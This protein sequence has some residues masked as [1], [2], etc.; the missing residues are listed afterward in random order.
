M[1]T[2]LLE[3]RPTQLL[4]MNLVEQL[5][6]LMQGVKG[7]KHVDTRLIITGQ[8]PV[9]P[10]VQIALYR[11]AQEALNNIVKHTHAT[12]IEIAYSSLPERVELSIWDNGSGFDPKQAKGGAGVEAMRERAASIQASLEIASSQQNGTRVSVRWVPEN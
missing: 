11:V 6:Q 8:Y 5:H 1:R 3:L 7:R 2:L 12:E 9:P 10:D 4:T